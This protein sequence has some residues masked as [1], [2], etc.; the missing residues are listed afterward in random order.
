MKYYKKL[1]ITMA[2]VFAIVGLLFLIAPD[3]VLSSFNSISNAIGM[4][5]APLNGMGFYLILAAGYM[6][7][8]TLIACLM[9]KYPEN[10]YFPLL[11]ANGKMIS[12]FLSLIMFVSH[13]PYLIYMVNFIVD[14]IIGSIVLIFYFLLV[15][16]T[17]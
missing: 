12:S 7:L 15:K 3:R 9:Y 13:Q 5:E 8:V 1:S 17:V 11:L 10:K 2:I 14:G 6:Y 16:K 4:K